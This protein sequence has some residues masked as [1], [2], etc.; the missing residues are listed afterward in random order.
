MYSD[1]N[2]TDGIA[3]VNTD[4]GVLY[5]KLKKFT[6]AKQYLERSLE[7]SKNANIKEIIKE[8]YA[9][10]SWLYSAQQNFKSAYGNYKMYVL[11]RDSLLNPGNLK[12]II[13]I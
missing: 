4:I 8:S 3:G 13:A 10:I 7:L 9:G 5:T 11:Y 6:D 12:K 1:I 2:K